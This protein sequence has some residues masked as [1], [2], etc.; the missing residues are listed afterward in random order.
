[1]DFT[2]LSSQ[3]CIQCG[4]VEP[5]PA[6]VSYPPRWGE[7][8]RGAPPRWNRPFNRL[9]SDE[10]IIRGVVGLRRGCEAGGGWGFLFPVYH[11]RDRIVDVAM[12]WRPDDARRLIPALSWGLLNSYDATMHVSGQINWWRIWLPMYR[13]DAL[14]FQVK[15]FFGM[16]P[17]M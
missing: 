16:T 14:W 9:R 11:V 5:Y 6:P 7:G 1:M 3:R 2:R 12:T 15:V 17:R 10:C 4:K 13:S 8:G